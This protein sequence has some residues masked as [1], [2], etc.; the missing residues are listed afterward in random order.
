MIDTGVGIP[1]AQL[2]RVFDLFTQVDRALNR[3]DSGLGIG[4][5]LV[6]WLVE[7]HNGTVIA[8]SPGPQQGTTITVRLPIL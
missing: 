5:A 3:L 7:M 2:E 1:P 6:R 8:E 4:L